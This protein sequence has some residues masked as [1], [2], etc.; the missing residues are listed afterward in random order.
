M[1]SVCLL[2]FSVVCCIVVRGE[3][4]GVVTAAN[5]CAAEVMFASG[6]FFQDCKRISEDPMTNSVIVA[7]WEK[8]VV[9]SVNHPEPYCNPQCNNGLCGEKFNGRERI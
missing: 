9:Q 8:C 3:G 7:W 1:V 5:N 6:A 4:S 2:E